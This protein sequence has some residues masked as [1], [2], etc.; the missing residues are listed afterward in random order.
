MSK[1]LSFFLIDFI[2]SIVFCHFY[3]FSRFLVFIGFY[4]LIDFVIFCRSHRFYQFCFID[5]IG[6]V[7]FFSISL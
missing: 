2:D 4:C 6:F 1:V 5:F 3:R 7:V